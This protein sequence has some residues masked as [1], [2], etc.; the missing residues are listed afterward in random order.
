MATES[1]ATTL[2]VRCLRPGP[3]SPDNSPI[4]AHGLK[5]RGLTDNSLALTALTLVLTTKS[6]LILKSLSAIYTGRMRVYATLSATQRNAVYPMLPLSSYSL[7]GI[8]PVYHS[9][10]N[11]W[12]LL[13]TLVRRHIPFWGCI[14]V[15]IQE[16]GYHPVLFTYGGLGTHLL[17]SAPQPRYWPSSDLPAIHITSGFLAFRTFVSRI[18]SPS[19]TIVALALPKT[20]ERE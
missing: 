10:S 11:G 1:T 17:L 12:D 7:P 3:T 8:P 6:F 2:R 20:R 4:A 15:S 19:A 16:Q 5:D 18:T 14:E 9:N 13:S